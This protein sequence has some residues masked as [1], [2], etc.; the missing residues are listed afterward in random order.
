MKSI[1]V[2]NINMKQLTFY[3]FVGVIGSVVDFAVFAGLQS[4][5]FAT[6]T[7]QWSAALIGNSH[8]HLWHHYKVFDHNE[9]FKKTY[10]FTLILALIIIISSGPVLLGLNH[11]FDNIWLSKVL[12]LPLTG[13]IGF[14]I[15]K[16]FIYFSKQQ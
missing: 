2:G 16:Y 4:F 11:F 3:I 1:E 14:V 15:R 13:V 10:S 5:A 7:S 8:N 6:V 12:L 9:K